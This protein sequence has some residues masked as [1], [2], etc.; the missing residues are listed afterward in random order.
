MDQT[1]PASPK[2]V[3]LVGTKVADDGQDQESPNGDAG[4]LTP[5]STPKKEDRDPTPANAIPAS[6]STEPTEIMESGAR[7]ATP[8][9]F[10]TTSTP[11]TSPSEKEEQ[12]SSRSGDG[13]ATTGAT[14]AVTTPLT[15]AAAAGSNH[16]QELTE[17]VDEKESESPIST[18]ELPPTRH[19]EELSK[20]DQ[21]T[22]ASQLIA[23]VPTQTPINPNGPS[24]TK[25][26][27]R[28]TAKTKNLF[29]AHDP[30][31]STADDACTRTGTAATPSVN[32]SGKDMFA[33]I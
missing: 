23:A 12:V 28:R 24:M 22:N 33:S 3:T 19:A 11:S 4:M 17:F 31:F 10:E 8:Q 20:P 30:L 15:Q 1:D 18:L 5:Q 32:E 27:A 14:V 26:I 2:Q 16:I 6:T 21:T 25:T 13:G 9:K 7:M 29:E